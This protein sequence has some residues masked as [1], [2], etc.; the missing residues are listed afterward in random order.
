MRK[1]RKITTKIT[2][3]TERVIV[4]SP[5]PGLES[6]CAACRSGV[7]RLTVEEAATVAGAD[8]MT[9]YR[10]IEAGLIHFSETDAGALLIC[11]SSLERYELKKKE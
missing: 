4:L 1:T 8:S 6:W 10:R 11:G 3:E 7:R 5:R 2:I 9:I